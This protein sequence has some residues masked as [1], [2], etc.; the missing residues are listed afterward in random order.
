[1]GAYLWVEHVLLEEGLEWGELAEELL[2]LEEDL[3]LDLLLEIELDPPLSLPLDPDLGNARRN[4][5]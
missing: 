3:D 4:G 5:Q 2:E 1:M